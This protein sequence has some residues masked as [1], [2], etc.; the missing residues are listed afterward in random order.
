MPCESEFSF[1]SPTAILIPK[2]ADEMI[3]TAA[4]DF[5]D[6]LFT[7]MGVSAYVGYECGDA[8]QGCVRFAFDEGMKENAKS[9]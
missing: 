5:A 2:N 3:L 7:S 9:R 6:Y 4:R 1:Q 8:P